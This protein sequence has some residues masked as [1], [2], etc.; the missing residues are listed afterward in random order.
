M[1]IL[2]SKKPVNFFQIIFPKNKKNNIK[3]IAT[4]V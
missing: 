1:S 2:E 3:D 4:Q